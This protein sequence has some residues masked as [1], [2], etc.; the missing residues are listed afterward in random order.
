MQAD[1][2]N[3]LNLNDDETLHKFPETIRSIIKP[4]DSYVQQEFAQYLKVMKA[5]K[6]IETKMVNNGDK[7][8]SP[9]YAVTGKLLI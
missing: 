2:P 6:S 5:M 3:T 1:E 9:D 7:I 4:L 8:A